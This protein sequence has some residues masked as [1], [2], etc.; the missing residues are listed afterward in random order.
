MSTSLV[1]STNISSYVNIQS[2][3]EH[4]NSLT[5]VIR[6]FDLFPNLIHFVQQLNSI[7]SEISIYLILSNGSFSATSVFPELAFPLNA[8][9]TRCNSLLCDNIVYS[10][11]AYEVS[12]YG[13]ILLWNESLPLERVLSIVKSPS[14]SFESAWFSIY[15]LYDIRQIISDSRFQTVL[16]QFNPITKIQN[17]A[18]GM[19]QKWNG[20]NESESRNH[21][22][23]SK[24][25]ATS[26]STA[27]SASVSS[28]TSPLNH[29]IAVVMNVFK[30]NYFDHVF[31][32]LCS[33]SLTPSYIIL[34]QNEAH[35]INLRSLI[36][37][38]C[39]R[40]NIIFFHIWNTN[41]NPYSF[42][43][44]FVPIPPEIQYTVIT[45]DDLFLQ[46]NAF[47]MGIKFVES[48]HCV[49]T[50]H[51]GKISNNTEGFDTWEDVRSSSDHIRFAD[52]ASLPQFS[53]TSW[54]KKVMK[55]PPFYRRFGDILF[56]SISLFQE[57]NIPPCIPPN[58]TF[59]EAS[60][61]N[62]SFSTL[63]KNRGLYADDYNRIASTWMKMGYVPL[64]QR[65][66]L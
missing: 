2:S 35:L 13:G 44:H 36:P 26:I 65:E 27:E 4:H 51:G 25:T 46:P 5:L 33:Q 41:W 31:S 12:D 17:F 19:N 3:G 11:L 48:Y 62:D 60:K 43:R 61:D 40:T 45:D 6:A 55:T 53:E 21:A 63:K 18:A 28:V 56:A 66:H 34:V 7:R 30:R 59:C 32:S 42:F 24:N 54:R 15:P 38:L 1:A 47:E 39:H 57:A 37:P 14:P 64:Y 23:D 52:Y 20:T 58:F 29:S 9:V 49:V 10:V 16:S 8:R 50:E 22:I